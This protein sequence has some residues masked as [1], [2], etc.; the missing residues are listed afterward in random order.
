MNAL[1]M[2]FYNR[3]SKYSL[4]LSEYFQMHQCPLNFEM[5]CATS[6]LGISWQH[7]NN[8]KFFAYSVLSISCVLSCPN[9]TASFRYSFAT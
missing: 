6:T 2:K 8:P 9:N 7:I 5:S 4:E 1:W 3:H